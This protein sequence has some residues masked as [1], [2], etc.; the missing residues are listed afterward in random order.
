MRDISQAILT[1]YTCVAMCYMKDKKK[2]TYLGVFDLLFIELKQAG[3]PM[4]CTSFVMDFELPMREAYV[5]QY[6]KHFGI[7]PEVRRTLVYVIL[8][9][10][11]GKP[12]YWCSYE[13]RITK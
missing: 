10:K 4:K 11:L 7:K 9:L 1:S 12:G 6:M 5:E 13:E 2:E 8:K 3:Y